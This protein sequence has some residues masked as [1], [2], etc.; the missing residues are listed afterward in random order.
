MLRVAL[1]RLAL[2]RVALPRV[3]LPRVA[4]WRVAL[5]RPEV[6]AQ[7]AKHWPFLAAAAAG[8]SL[9]RSQLQKGRAASPDRLLPREVAGLLQGT[10][11]LQ[12]RKDE[13]AAAPP[14]PMSMVGEERGL[15]GCH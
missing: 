4:L 13:M 6:P 2:P 15:P 9:A 1:L 10:E 8:D 14:A 5:P 12:R 3:A 7:L 11:P